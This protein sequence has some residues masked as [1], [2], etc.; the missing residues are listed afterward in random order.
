MERR[1]LLWHAESR[2]GQVSA[3]END[4]DAFFGLG[5]TYEFTEQWAVRGEYDRF[6]LDDT[7]I[8]T[9]FASVVF[10]F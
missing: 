6:Q 2:V 8:D 4:T 7:D 10:S 3:G 5:A 9:L 1:P